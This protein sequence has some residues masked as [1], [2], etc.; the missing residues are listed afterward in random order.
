M[1]RSILIRGARQLLTLHGAG[2][3]RRGE[4]LRDLG[5]IEDG[6][7][8]IVNGAIASVG[9]TR[10][11]ENL[12]AAREAEEINAA[13]RVVLPGFVD[14]HTQL[15]GAPLKVAQLRRAGARAGRE[16]G[17]PMRWNALQTSIQYVRNTP[18]PTL[19]AQ[20]RKQIEAC[21]RHGTTTIEAQTGFGLSTSMEMK[22]LRVLNALNDGCIS[23]APSFF[24]ARMLPGD[25]LGR[26]QE[27]LSTIC[28]EIV[29]KLRERRFAS[30]VGI[31]C[32]PS[33]FSIEHARP[34]LEC[35]RRHG[36]SVKVHADQ[37]AR[38][39]AVLLAVDV[40][41]ASVDGLNH[42]HGT[43]IDELARSGTVA[44]LLPAAVHQGAYSRFPPA[45]ELLDAG[46]A[47]ALASAFDPAI[48]S[49]FN[50]QM[51]ISLA[52]THM[53]MS[54]EE[55]ICA[56]TINGAHA[57]ESAPRTGSLEFGKNADI[58]ILNASDYRELA[59][60]FGG[61]M[62]ALVMRKGEVAYREGAVTCA[63]P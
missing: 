36:M 53:N 16:E 27:Y 5:V 41:A 18:A 14:S 12:A 11:I 34:F 28:S 32:N 60:Y 30:F 25:F 52:C 1:K 48:S 58:I 45:R 38:T 46:A 44:T 55:A 13:G 10:R 20:A 22:M 42:I 49:T 59:Y 24:G 8:L 7:V 33:G 43:D 54:V 29:P 19:E 62:V 2:G 23:I 35:A 63:E 15:L 26:P 37:D 40:G 9:P 61:N 3:P 6:S 17:A 21:L 56:A 31:N 4:A 57:V 51:V 50:M 39:D 47:V